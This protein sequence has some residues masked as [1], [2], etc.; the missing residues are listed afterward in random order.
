MLRDERGHLS[1][2]ANLSDLRSRIS[3]LRNDFPGYRV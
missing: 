2:Q 3:P 1:I